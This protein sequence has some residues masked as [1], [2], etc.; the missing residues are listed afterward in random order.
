MKKRRLKHASLPF[1]LDEALSASEQSLLHAAYAAGRGELIG[2]AEPRHPNVVESHFENAISAFVTNRA[3]RGYDEI[4]RGIHKALLRLGRSKRKTSRSPMSRPTSSRIVAKATFYSRS[5]K[6][7]KRRRD[8]HKGMQLHIS[9]IGGEV[10][11]VWVENV[12]RDFSDLDVRYNV[13]ELAR[14]GDKTA[15]LALPFIRVSLNRPDARGVR[16][17]KD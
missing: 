13:E 9:L 7:Q 5:G 4:D 8:P 3:T 11:G 14:E 16:V 6:R 10:E 1:A 2:H 12:P 15:K 17:Y